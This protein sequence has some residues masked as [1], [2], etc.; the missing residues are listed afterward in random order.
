MQADV[1]SQK[2]PGLDEVLVTDRKA[3]GMDSSDHH[4]RSDDVLMMI[5]GQDTGQ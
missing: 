1:V 5:Q 4:V 3:L 2:R